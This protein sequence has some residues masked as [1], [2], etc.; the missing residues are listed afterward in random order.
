M[1]NSLNQEALDDGNGSFVKRSGNEANEM[2]S[3]A[4]GIY[5]LMDLSLQFTSK[6]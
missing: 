2:K 4:K 5:K 6:N 3:L 1:K